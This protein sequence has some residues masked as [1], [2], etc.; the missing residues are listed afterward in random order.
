M[1]TL[2]VTPDELRDLIAQ[3]ETMEVEFK[4]A[5][6]NA[7]SDRNLVEAVVCLANGNGG[8]LLLGVEDDGRIS[9][10]APRHGD[11]TQPH[12]IVG[13]I[14]N[15]TDPHLPVVAEVVE[16]GGKDVVHI[17]VPPA[18]TGPVGTRDGVFKRRS[19]KPDGT[20]ECIPYRAS[21]MQSAAFDLTG[22]DYAT[23]PAVGSSMADL[24]EGEFDRFRAMCAG[25]GDV[26]LTDLSSVD[27]LRA[28]RLD[29][30]EGRAV[31]P[32]LGAVL[33][34]GSRN[35]LDRW[36][37]TAE[38][39]FQDTRTNYESENVSLRLPLLAAAEALERRIEVRNASAQILMGMVRVDVPQLASTTVREVIANALVHRSYADLGPVLVQFGDDALTVTSPGGFPAGVTLDNLLDQ[40]RPRSVA[41]ADAFKRAGLVER[42][43]KGV[44]EMY[45]NQLRAGR[46]EP[47]YSRSTSASVQV[48]L[49]T[50]RADLDLVRFVLT[51]ERDMRVRLGMEEIR[52]VHHLRSMGPCT[53]AELAHD[54]RTPVVP[55]RALAQRL[56][57]RGVI[58]SRGAGRNRRFHLTARFYALAEDRGAYVRVRGIDALQ[59]EHMV[60]EYVR[61]YGHIS[62]AQAAELTQIS[63]DE[64][65]K[66]LRRLA[67]EGKL[68]M[69]GQRRTARYELPEQP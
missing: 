1:H 13:L 49:P 21:E 12:R 35:A 53:A 54:L 61:Q 58:E 29:A 63:P 4:R 31:V 18:R 57:E 45:D 59:Q 32:S 25:G 8:H 47:D 23:L 26:A 46:G 37:P 51:Y 38:C 60:F 33:L 55:T 19:L 41:L 62:R 10:A 9:G 30:G 52:V 27:L 15:Q 3:G 7:L 40:S 48:V 67:A 44:N 22:V 65:S 66:L 16:L 50:G 17:Q 14:L 56:V 43:G 24:D 28:L 68:T 69:V 2:V 36:A 64:A 42:R 20:P 11:V 5:T 34:F 39:L 6:R